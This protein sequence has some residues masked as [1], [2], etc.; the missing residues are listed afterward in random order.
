MTAIYEFLGC[1]IFSLAVDE[2]NFAVFDNL[3]KTALLVRARAMASIVKD[4]NHNNEAR[5]LNA[6]TLIN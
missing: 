6:R 4:L 2:L 1:H 5:N 3:V